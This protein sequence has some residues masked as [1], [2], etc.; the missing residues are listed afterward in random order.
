MVPTDEAI[1]TRQMLYSAL[2][3]P[4]TAAFAINFLHLPEVFVRDLTFESVAVS[5][6]TRHTA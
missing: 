5:G 6:T 2:P 4:A 3:V 1:I